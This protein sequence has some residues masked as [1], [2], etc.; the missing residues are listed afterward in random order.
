MAYRPLVR[1][2]ERLENVLFPRCVRSSPIQWFARLYSKPQPLRSRVKP[3][4]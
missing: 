3:A 2:P 4:D 1:E